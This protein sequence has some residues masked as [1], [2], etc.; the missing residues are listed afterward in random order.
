MG[1]EREEG[2]FLRE[3]VLCF[4][5]NLIIVFVE[6]FKPAH[7]GLGTTLLLHSTLYRLKRSASY[8]Q[9]LCIE[10]GVC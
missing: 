8:T 1:I 5:Y 2:L 4:K 10:P 7:G 9:R 6:A 3:L